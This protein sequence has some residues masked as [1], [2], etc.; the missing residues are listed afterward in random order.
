MTKHFTP[1]FLWL[2]RKIW[3]L[4]RKCWLFLWTDKIPLVANMGLILLTAWLTYAVAPKINS[5]FERQK[6]QS[7][8]VLENLRGINGLV[9]DLYVEITYINYSVAKSGNVPTERI[10]KAREVIGRLDWKLIETAAVLESES[11]RRL[12]REFQ[13]RLSM[14]RIALDNTSDRATAELVLKAADEMAASAVKVIAAVGKRASLDPK[15]DP[16]S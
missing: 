11:D 10:S 13:Q 3:W 9:S 2:L 1:A 7:A 6:I 15:S 5:R 12:L 8:Y 14:V 16:D 4:L